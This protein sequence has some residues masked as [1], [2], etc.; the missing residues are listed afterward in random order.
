[1][2][3][4]NAPQEKISA[5]TDG[6]LEPSELDAAFASL[7][8]PEGRKDWDLYHQI[9]DVLRSEEMAVEMSPDFAARMAAKLDAEPTIL[10]PVAQASKKQSA[11]ICS[12]SDMA[13]RFAMPGLAAVL[14]V[15]TAYLVAPQLITDGD[16][17]P[18]Q[19]YASSSLASAGT[20]AMAP[21][22]SIP[23]MPVAV[24]VTANASADSNPE[25]VVLR[26]P[27]I[28]EYLIAHQ[29]YSPS[30][31]DTTQFVQSAAFET[32]PQK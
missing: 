7:R 25:A 29:R 12:K 31:Y 27:A 16:T 8:Q 22:A 9:G 13:K 26:D 1:M 3:N 24:P 5:L 18:T 23:A 20:Q 2:K 28:D 21:V 11:A 32:K 6:E 14:A 19:N 4:D 17:K 15:F 30:L 10:A